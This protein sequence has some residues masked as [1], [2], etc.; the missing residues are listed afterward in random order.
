MHLRKLFDFEEAYAETVATPGF[1]VG[2]LD[3]ALLARVRKKQLMFLHYDNDPEWSGRLLTLWQVLEAMFP[4]AD[5]ATSEE[6]PS[7]SSSDTWCIACVMANYERGSFQQL[8]HFEPLYP[9]QQVGQELWDRLAPVCASKLANKIKKCGD[10]LPAEDES[11][12]EF[13]AS[14]R[15]YL[16]QLKRQQVFT[17]LMHQMSF[18]PAPVPA[19]GNCG[20]WTLLALEGGPVSRAQMACFT[21]AIGVSVTDAR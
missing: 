2:L 15:E 8:N 18:H 16:E 5:V 4:D 3:L 6:P 19:D 13:S 20:L 14:A 11:E 10:A 1:Y 12:D 21:A 17:Q 7:L 9:L